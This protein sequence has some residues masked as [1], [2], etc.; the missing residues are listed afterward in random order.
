LLLAPAF[1]IIRAT[2]NAITYRKDHVR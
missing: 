2:V 1:F